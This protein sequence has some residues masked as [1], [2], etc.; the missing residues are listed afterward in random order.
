MTS[1][2]TRCPL[3]GSETDAAA[4]RDPQEIRRQIERLQE[5]LRETEPGAQEHPHTAT[6]GYGA[7][8]TEA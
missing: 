7:D 6:G 8:P 1:S 4:T 3:C 5:L 2:S